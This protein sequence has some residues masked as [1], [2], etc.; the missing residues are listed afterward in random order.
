[1]PNLHSAR[2]I[3]KISSNAIHL[4]INLKHEK[5]NSG[6]FK[7]FVQLWVGI[8]EFHLTDLS[9]FYQPCDRGIGNIIALEYL[10]LKNCLKSPFQRYSRK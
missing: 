2:Q 5:V 10:F 3:R 6:A 9:D 4:M 8:C 7:N 1:M